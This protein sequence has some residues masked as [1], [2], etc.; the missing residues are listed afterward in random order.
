[1]SDSTTEA[2]TTSIAT[3]QQSADA[4]LKKWETTIQS[5]PIQSIAWAALIGYVF[6]II[7]IGRIL[8]T[9]LHILTTLIRPALFVFGTIAI[10]KLFKNKP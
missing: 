8:F 5:A 2:A 10:F 1:M 4:C 3:L 9:L 7:P 6:R